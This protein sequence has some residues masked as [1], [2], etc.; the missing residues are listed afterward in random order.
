[1]GIKSNQ[2]RIIV[3]FMLAILT[4]VFAAN[5]AYANPL[6]PPPESL[7]TILINADG[8]VTPPTDVIERDGDVYYLTRDVFQE[9]TLK[10]NCSNI[11]LDG[12]NHLIDGAG[13]G[14]NGV[15]LTSVANVTIRNLRLKDFYFEGLSLF[16]SSKCTI[17]AVNTLD[18]KYAGIKLS[19]SCNNTITANQITNVKQLNGSSGIVFGSSYVLG[20][21]YQNSI[22]GNNITG[23]YYVFRVE[24][25]SSG[26]SV[27][28]NNFLNYSQPVLSTTNKHMMN[29]W[30]DGTVGNYWSTYDGEDSNRDGIGDIPYMLDLH[31]KDNYPL[32]APANASSTPSASATT[33]EV[34]SALT[35]SEFTP[36]VGVAL[37]V[38]TVVLC[39]RFR[40]KIA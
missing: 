19:D 30:D 28:A 24:G 13:A 25:N 2:T 12:M 5:L 37:I 1:M 21:A 40:K 6:P 36:A 11:V 33:P 29:F 17:T 32:M 20:G 3:W 15:M 14:S 31:D 4:W 16:N 34:S 26:N 10:V 8:N 38:I 18:T 27:Y 9:Y 7:P 39:L 23:L 22:F 35:T